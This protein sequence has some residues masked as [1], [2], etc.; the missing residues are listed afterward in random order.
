[1]LGQCGLFWG[2]QSSEGVGG[3]PTAMVRALTMSLLSCY[4]LNQVTQPSLSFI[5]LI[6]EMGMIPPTLC[7]M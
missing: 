6:C 5:L 2:Q 3:G 7:A 1:M 4:P